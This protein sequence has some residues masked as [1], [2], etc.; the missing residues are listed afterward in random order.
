MGLALLTGVNSLPLLNRLPLPGVLRNSLPATGAESV[1]RIAISLAEEAR[2]AVIVA[3]LA[4]QSG[5]SFSLQLRQK[6]SSCIR[7]ALALIKSE[8]QM[9]LKHAV[10]Y[11]IRIFFSLKG[12]K[13]RLTVFGICNA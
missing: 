9:R 10:Q 6:G 13:L 8:S 5:Y 3:S 11:S 1:L 7:K 12:R 4:C 2:L